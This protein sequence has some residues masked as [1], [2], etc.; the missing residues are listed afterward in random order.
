MSDVEMPDP[1][2]VPQTDR[3][4]ESDHD[5]GDSEPES[6]ESPVD[7]MV[8]SRARR[9]NAGNRMSTLLAKTAQEEGEE[10]GEEWEEAPDE[11]DF[12]GDNV[13]EQDDYN[14]ESSTLR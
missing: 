14:M 6:P 5:N 8:T 2:H 1:D 12:E 7:L 10:W 4:I 9:A 11:E 3:D 13:N